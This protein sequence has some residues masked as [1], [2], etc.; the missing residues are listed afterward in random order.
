ML[1]TLGLVLPLLFAGCIGGGD[2]DPTDSGLLDSEACELAADHDACPE[3][4]S[5]P[6]TC[7][8]E[9]TTVTENSCG[10]CQARSTLYQQLCDDGSEATRSTIEDETVCDSGQSD[11]CVLAETFSS[12]DECY[13]GQVTCTYGDASATQASCG[14]CQ[15]RGALYQQL[16]DS[17]VGDTQEELE[18]GT[19]CE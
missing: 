7:T 17:G 16:C 2:D 8:F 18:A 1:R 14:D 6:A 5:G 11:A 15:A 9:D 12:C 3:C 4:S 10:D 13:D 19:V